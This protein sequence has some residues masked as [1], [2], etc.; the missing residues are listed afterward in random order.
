M[1]ILHLHFCLFGC[2]CHLVDL[3]HTVT[4]R[5]VQEFLFDFGFNRLS[6][7]NFRVIRW[8]V[9][10]SSYGL[11]EIFLFLPYE[12]NI[13]ILTASLQTLKRSCGLTRVKSNTIWPELFL[14]I[15]F[16]LPDTGKKIFMCIMAWDNSLPGDITYLLWKRKSPRWS[17]KRYPAILMSRETAKDLFIYLVGVI[18]LVLKNLRRR[19]VLWLEETRLDPHGKP[20]AISRMRVD[21]SMYGLRESQLST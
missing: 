18:W 5:L 8:V 7:L 9:R 10:C 19:R 11:I 6:K 20:T 2:R 1:I 13:F 4:L 3:M 21:L 12:S 16:P 15:S 14:R 17:I